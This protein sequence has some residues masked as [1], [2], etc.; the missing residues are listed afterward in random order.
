MKIDDMDKEKSKKVQ[1]MTLR[2]YYDSLP[3]ASFPKADFVKR[4]TIECHCTDAC[5]R[6]WLRGASVP[7]KWRREKVAEIT[8]ISEESLWKR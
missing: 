5:V 4:L 2:D 3:S 7:N 8:G 6:G 1:N